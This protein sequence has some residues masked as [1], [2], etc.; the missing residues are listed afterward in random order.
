[1]TTEDMIEVLIENGVKSYKKLN[2]NTKEAIFLNQHREVEIERIKFS[3]WREYA[4]YKTGEQLQEI[5]PYAEVQVELDGNNS[6]ISLTV[7][8]KEQQKVNAFLYSFLKSQKL[9]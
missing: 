6:R 7:S 1:M 2:K 9:V 4:T 8:N 5:L 3:Y